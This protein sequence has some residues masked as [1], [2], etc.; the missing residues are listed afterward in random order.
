MYVYLFLCI[1]LFYIRKQLSKK[2]SMSQ[3]SRLHGT[4]AAKD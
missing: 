4:N 3:G 1:K 2:E